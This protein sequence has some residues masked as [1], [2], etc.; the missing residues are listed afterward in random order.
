MTSVLDNVFS[1]PYERTHTCK[2]CANYTVAFRGLFVVIRLM[3]LAAYAGITG[4][5]KIK[6]IFSNTVNKVIK[7]SG[8]CHGK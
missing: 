7:L 4:K 2:Q 5:K 6:K 1:A 3:S 8:K